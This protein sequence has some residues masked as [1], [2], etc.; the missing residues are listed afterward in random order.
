MTARRDKRRVEVLFILIE[1]LKYFFLSLQMDKKESMEVLPGR[2]RTLQPGVVL[3]LHQ[4][5]HP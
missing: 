3:T 4:A 2:V 5:A 1:T